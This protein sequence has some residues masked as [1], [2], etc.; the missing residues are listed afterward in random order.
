LGNNKK[1]AARPIGAGEKGLCIPTKVF[2][3]RRDFTGRLKI[4]VKN[5]ILPHKRGLKFC[6]TFA[7]YGI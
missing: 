2:R 4:F 7:K 3:E 5:R 1:Y 6:F